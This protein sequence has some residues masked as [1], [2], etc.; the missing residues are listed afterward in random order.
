MLQ[1]PNNLEVADNLF[2][3]NTAGNSGGGLA[4]IGSGDASGNSAVV[5]GNTF[6]SN[7][8]TFTPH[9]LCT[10]R[11]CC[12]AQVALRAQLLRRVGGQ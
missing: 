8:V 12:K 2:Q 11:C 6:V 9:L 3:G 10:G 1:S 7:E 5:T 4:V